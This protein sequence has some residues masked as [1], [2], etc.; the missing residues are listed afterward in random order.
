MADLTRLKA[1]LRAHRPDPELSIEQ[2]RALMAADA[3][4]LPGVEGVEVE[5]VDAGGVPA[6]S[7]TAAG[8][9]HDRT[10][11]YL[12]GGGYCAGSVGAVRALGGRLALASAARVLTLDYGLAPERPFPAGR[13]DAVRA[14]RWLRATGTDPARIVIGGDSAGGGLAIAVLVALR[15]AG[16]PLPSAAFALSPWSDLRLTVESV[17]RNAEADP[18]VSPR[19]LRRFADWYTTGGAETGDAGVSP[20]LADL[21]GLPRLLV[22][23]GEDECLVDDATRLAERVRASGGEVELE[24]WPEVVH[25]WHLLAPRFEQANKAIDRVGDWLRSPVEGAGDGMAGR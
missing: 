7:I 13:D 21:A 3:D 25:V 8:G 1:A 5:Q 10:I 22:Q 24:T 17:E 2:I 12:H 9:A 19:L 20:V 6:E 15:D 16:D 14:Y 11:L 4:G 18:I 23:V